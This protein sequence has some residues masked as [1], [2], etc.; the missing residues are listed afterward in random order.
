MN[1]VGKSTAP[2]FTSR[3]FSGATVLG[4]NHQRLI[5]I[6]RYSL[7]QGKMSAPAG[8]K[9]MCARYRLPQSITAPSALISLRVAATAVGVILALVTSKLSLAD[10]G[11]N[12][13][14]L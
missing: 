14:Y 8:T 5:E 3:C 4:N 12:S 11:G 6:C 1:V 9:N 10:E 7:R 13:M 2:R